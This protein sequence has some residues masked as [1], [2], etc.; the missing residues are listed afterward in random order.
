M[1]DFLVKEDPREYIP[2]VWFWMWCIFVVLGF[3]CELRE[4]ITRLEEKDK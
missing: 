3:I 2:L 4:M 1:F